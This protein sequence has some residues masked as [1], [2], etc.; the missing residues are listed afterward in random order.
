MIR[1]TDHFWGFFRGTPVSGT[2]KYHD[3][4]LGKLLRDLK[5]DDIL[6]ISENI[7]FGQKS[8]GGDEYTA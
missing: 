7:P 2:K 6:I 3:R 4:K 8:Y 1:L 5:E